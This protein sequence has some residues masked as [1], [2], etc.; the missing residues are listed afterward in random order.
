MRR[1]SYYVDTCIWLNLFKKEECTK[2]GVPYHK[3][4]KGFLERFSKNIFYS[5][6]TRKEIKAK[7]DEKAFYEKNEFMMERFRFVYTT[8]EDYK[9]AK[10]LKAQLKDKLSFY[11]YV[12]IGVCRR[13]NLILITRD[14]S[15]IKIG[16]SFVSVKRPEELLP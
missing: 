11:D 10:G 13:L 2:Q 14:R 16:R 9:F 5:E 7:L 1:K 8:K 12:H 6:V 4:A 3:I 15:L